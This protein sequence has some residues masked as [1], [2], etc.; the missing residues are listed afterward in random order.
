MSAERSRPPAATRNLAGI[1]LTVIGVLCF[2]GLDAS[3]KWLN[4][5]LSPLQ[6]VAVRYIGSFLVIA[7]F[8]NPWRRPGI[9]RT[10]HLALQ[11]SRALCLLLATVCSFSAL[12][13]LSLT[14]LTSITFTSPLIVALIAGPF[15]GERIG[16]RR[17]VAVL[18]GFAG[19]L[20]VTRPFGGAL[21]PAALLA[22]IN[23]SACAFYYIMTRRLAAH[24]PT[25]TT[26]FYTG[27]VG[28]LACAP[29]VPFVW[30]TPTAPRIW[31]VM[32]ALAGL[33]ALAHW[34]LIL[35]HKRAPASVL[36][37]FFYAQLLGATGLGWLVF[38][39]IPDRWTIVGGLI[40]ISSGLYLVYR[41]RV[42]QKFPSTDVAP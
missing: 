3:A 21:H 16:P 2:S 32:L 6:T 24:D 20:V 25:E 15:L 30:T 31:L 8:L 28:A 22:V 29:F 5:S 36:A 23:A 19:V 18:A 17:V 11:C 42:R 38:G 37:P 34:L 4:H 27:F 14:L 26:M 7:P 39:E 13:Y 41:E 10:H 33:G 9:L 35:A 40:V 1:A 12:R